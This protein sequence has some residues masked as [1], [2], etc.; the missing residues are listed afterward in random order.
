MSCF[1]RT[2][3][4]CFTSVKDQFNPRKSKK[5]LKVQNFEVVNLVICASFILCHS[6]IWLLGAEV[7]FLPKNLILKY[8][9]KLMRFQLL[10]DQNKSTGKV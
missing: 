3:I 1:W 6:K 5:T 10:L 2:K 9:Q 7:I 4:V 8:F